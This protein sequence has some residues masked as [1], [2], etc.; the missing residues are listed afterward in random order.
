MRCQ[1]MLILPMALVAVPLAAQGFEGVLTI[2]MPNA[3][4]PDMTWSIKGTK[5][6]GAFTV[7]NDQTGDV[8]TRYYVDNAA[9]TTTSLVQVPGMEASS[10][11][12]GI[13]MVRDLFPPV[14][15][16][17]PKPRKLGTSQ[18]VAGIKCDDYELTDAAKTRA[19]LATGLGAFVYPQSPAN[20]RVITSN[21]DAGQAAAMADAETRAR[22]APVRIVAGD[23]GG[24]GGATF[25][26]M[27]GDGGGAP[28]T[29]IVNGQVMNMGDG[30][31][32]AI[33]TGPIRMGGGAGA[34]PSWARAIG[35]NGFPLR[36]WSTNGTTVFEVQ[37]VTKSAV[38][39]RAVTV[40]EGFTEM[41]MPS[42]GG[43]IT[44]MFG[45]SSGNGMVRAGAV[46]GGGGG[47]ITRSVGGD[48]SV[49][50][51]RAGGGGGL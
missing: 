24:G 40:P 49:T 34:G 20:T 16:A 15:A 37:S 1:K 4:V 12:K 33:S 13:M 28:P 43:T 44:R 41:R 11:N 8:E 14:D 17:A 38:S 22:S 36:V 46:G 3:P 35:N 2:K 30:G 39:D 5:A 31:N 7:R 48:S 9:N 26:R 10:G 50:I 42:G 21:G 18:T 29:M 47:M 6:V 19:C 27:G 23:Q 25:V 51:I 32:G 45:D